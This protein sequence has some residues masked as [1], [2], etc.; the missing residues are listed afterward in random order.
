L[1][2]E[3]IEL[4]HGFAG[5]VTGVDSRKPLSSA[6]VAAVHAGMND[7]AVLVFRDQTLS[8]EAISGKPA[9]RETVRPS[10]RLNA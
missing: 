6:D 3:I 1:S 10:P 8:D 9:L 4:G 2:I 7:Y 5:E